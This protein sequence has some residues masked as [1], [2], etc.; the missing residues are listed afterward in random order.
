MYPLPNLM[1]GA[2][3]IFIR[4]G[5]T[6]CLVLHGFMASPGEVGWLGRD[7]GGRGYTVYVPRLTGHGYRPE[8]MRRMRWEDW[9]GQVLDGYHLL[10]QQ[11]AKVVVVGHSMGGLLALLLASAHP[12]DALAVCATPIEAPSPLL[13]WAWL[14][15]YVLP[16]THHPNEA[17]LHTVILEEQE[18]RGEAPIGRVHYAKWSSRAVAQFNRL[19][20]AAQDRLSLVR[21]PLLLLYA[22]DDKTAPQAHMHKIAEA[23]ASPQIEKR[24]LTA[25]AHILFQDVGRE[26]A[27]TIVAD[28]IAGI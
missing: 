4:G 6:G 14:I 20:R 3:P 15:A 9:Y 2:E 21:A 5:A 26:E 22:N 16:Y 25:G 23:V 1:P 19:L 18:R 13:P 7:L 27:F 12:I 17:E 24:L 10:R 11:C 8:D 28:F